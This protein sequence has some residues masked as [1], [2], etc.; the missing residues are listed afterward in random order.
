MVSEVQEVRE[1]EGRLYSKVFQLYSDQIT[2]QYLYDNS[3]G[4]MEMRELR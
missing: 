2:E 1:M 3:S 4:A